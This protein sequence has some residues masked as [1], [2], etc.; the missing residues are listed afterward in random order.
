M[1]ID[2]LFLGSILVSAFI[3]YIIL[4]SFLEQLKVNK[5]G[6]E[7]K[8]TKSVSNDTKVGDYVQFSGKL[9][10]PE[11]MSPIERRKCGYWYLIVRGVFTSKKKKPSKGY[12]THKPVILKKGSE[13]VPFVVSNGETSVQF[14]FKTHKDL[15]FNLNKST[16]QST[17]SPW[18]EGKDKVAKE[19][20]KAKYKKYESQ[21][22]S[23]PRK[24]DITCWG[25]VIAAT[26][27]SF[28]LAESKRSE[29]P[30]IIY[31]G[32]KGDFFSRI[33]NV[34]KS[35]IGLSLFL[36]MSL[37]AMWLWGSAIFNK[38]LFLAIL[39]VLA[40]SAFFVRRQTNRVLKG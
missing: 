11:L 26:S 23:L 38:E 1:M 5:M 21:V 14:A 3:G 2:Y 10:T 24:A 17:Q 18:F 25:K 27:N 37:L 32:F 35:Q 9:S 39:S 12:Q 28:I 33:S 7:L 36:I 6:Q 22:F 15:I 13:D 40:V 19:V 16:K 20:W 34:K 29:Q 4:R 30:T 31:N 8:G